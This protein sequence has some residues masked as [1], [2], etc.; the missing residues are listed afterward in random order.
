V[1]ESAFAA[2]GAVSYGIAAVGW[3]LLAARIAIGFKGNRRGAVLL[4]VAL[5]TSLWA[6]VGV[7]YARTHALVPLVALDVADTL[8]YALWFTFVAVLLRGTDGTASAGL[9]RWLVGLAIALCGGS[10][11]L[12]DG[13]GPLHALFGGD[14]RPDFA[15]HVALAI[16]AL[17]YVEQLFR[18]VHPQARWGVK[19]LVVAMAA[20]FGFD[21]FLF[22]DALL[23]GR[24]DPDFWLARGAAN[25]LVIPLVAIATAR[26][27]G[28]TVEMHLSR[29]VVFQSTALLVSGVFLLAVAG[30]GYIVRYIGGDWGRALQVELLFAAALLVALTMTSGRFRSRLRVFVSKHF[31]SYRYD[32]REEWLRFTRTLS[33]ESS[34]IGVQERAIAA[35][36]DLV[37]SP[38]GA[39]WL[40]DAS[41]VFRPAAR[42]NAS[43]AEESVA[44]DD[45]LPAFL[46]RSGWIVSLPE[47]TLHPDR[48]PDLALPPALRAM[49]EAWLVVPLPVGNALVGFVVLLDPRTPVEIDW[50]VRDLLK[51]AA[52]AAAAYLQQLRVSEVL[53]ETRKFDAF[54]RMSAFV[55]HDLKNLV[56]QLTLMLR[57]AERHRDN[58]AFQRD[59]LETVSH[60][61]GRM[62]ALMLQLRAGTTPIDNPRA[63]D[64]AA[65]V[66][67]V[68]A[69]KP[70]ADEV[71]LAIAP[72]LAALGHEERLDHV[73]GHLLQNALDATQA[74]GSVR[75]AARREAA[76]V[77]VEVADTGVGMS[78]AFVRERLFKPFETTKS[79]GMGIGV[80]ESQQYVASLGGRIEVDSGEGR[81]TT[82]V[83]RLP[84]ADTTPAPRQDESIASTAS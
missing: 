79:A 51:A 77:V 55:V 6:A 7:T 53:L 29:E 38:G 52:R 26:N 80:Y 58:P 45:V 19:P 65:L 25:A 54:N 8:R 10:L 66:R 81:G 76:E 40:A 50:E 34:V 56:A 83:V 31:F 43:P 41:G 39:L 21:L 49:P 75:I 16:L 69:A 64:V 60:V 17:V 37:E 62:N 4:A 11:L 67:R 63:V 20:L 2:A 1:T 23:F 47:A 42:L 71:A 68:V 22:A 27:A 15:L 46:V 84:A 5:A 59:M 28:W 70:R 9:P 82:V 78:P 74:G 24:L 72:G 3:L 33:T 30:A 48:Y 73:I 44:A 61:V 13:I 57:N 18:R 32:Y 14:L 36:A 12:L 35:L